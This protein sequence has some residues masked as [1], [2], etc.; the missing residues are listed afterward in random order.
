MDA[1]QIDWAVAAYSQAL[2][3]NPEA[4]DAYKNPACALIKERNWDDS[5]KT[6]ERVIESICPEGPGVAKALV[7]L[8]IAFEAGGDVA[9]AIRACR[10]AVELRPDCPEAHLNL[11]LSLLIQG[12]FSEGWKEH[13]WRWRCKDNP[14]PRRDFSVRQW[15]GSDLGGKTILLHCEQGLGD[16]IQ[17]IRYVPLVGARGGRVVVGCPAEL[18]RLLSSVA[19]IDKLVTSDA[20]GPL[21]VHCPLLSLPLVFGTR[22][23]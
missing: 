23:D 9:A 17:F 6:C 10:R 14:T 1:G 16:S 19:G 18:L 21:N 13:E 5:I 11:A 7:Q 2:R 22:L 3:L 12:E 15:D 4:E 8:G 20:V